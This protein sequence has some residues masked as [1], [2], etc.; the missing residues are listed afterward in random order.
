MK[1][2][3]S[4]MIVDADSY[5]TYGLSQGLQAFF[6]FHQQEILLLDETQLEHNVN[7]DIVFLGNLVTSP[8]WLYRLHQRNCHPM[9]FFIKDQGR[10]KNPFT[11]KTQCEKCNA[12]TLYRHQALPALY[13]LLDN[14]LT[15]Q[16]LQAKSAYHDCSCMSPLTPREADVLWCIHQGMNGRDTGTY[17]SISEKTANTHKQNAMRKLNFR[18]NQEL[19]QWLL[20][21]GGHYLNERPEAKHYAPLQ[22]PEAVT[23][24]NFLSPAQLMAL[25]KSCLPFQRRHAETYA[26]GAYITAIK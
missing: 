26:A 18:C 20:Q 17:L 23:E 10:S 7:I 1:Q 14:A 9:V 19:Y 3:L 24:D 12:G 4:I 22:Q 25:E 11:R 15:S 21:G 5:F 8:P 16:P 13:D 2:P 6:K